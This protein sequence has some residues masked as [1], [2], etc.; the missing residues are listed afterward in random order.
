MSGQ[1]F[2]FFAIVI[3][4]DIHAIRHIAKKE[5]VNSLN[6]FDVVHQCMLEYALIIFTFFFRNAI[7]YYL[8]CATYAIQLNC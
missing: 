4:V 3:I 7:V 2:Y 6:T 5:F 8:S 1:R